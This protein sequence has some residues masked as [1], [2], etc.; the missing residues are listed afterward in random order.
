MEVDG[1]PP[2]DRQTAGGA[3]I[4][5]AEVTVISGEGDARFPKVI[6]E[7]GMRLSRPQR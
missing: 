5:T 1:H 3:S 7:E 4:A 2:P 6:R